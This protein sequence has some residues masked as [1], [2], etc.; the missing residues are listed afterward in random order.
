M[1][2]LTTA[3]LVNAPQELAFAVLWDVTRYPEFLSD[4]VDVI[5]EPGD[6]PG[7]QIVHYVV[8]APRKLE[9]SLLMRAVAPE[10]IDWTLLES[11]LQRQNRGSWVFSL[12]PDGALLTLEIQ[13][14]FKLPV[15]DVIMKKLVEFNL[16]VMMRQVRA[17]IEQTNR[18][19]S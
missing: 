9:Y 2:E 11:D 6:S 15:P 16:P 10:R 1:F 17:R 13:M 4:V 14:E 19:S 3:I 5:A 7:E 18:G 8:R 12:A